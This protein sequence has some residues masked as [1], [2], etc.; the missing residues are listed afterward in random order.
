MLSAEL[1]ADVSRFL[2]R[3]AALLDAGQFDAWLELMDPEVTYVVPVR[4][5]RYGPPASEFS[6]TSFHLNETL[7]T[8]R[9]RVARLQTKYAWAED[10]PTHYRHFVSNIDV[11][12]TAEAVTEVE[13]NLLLY[14]GRGGETAGEFV[15]ARRCDV[16]RRTESGLRL[17]SRKVLADQTVWPTSALTTFL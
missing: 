16:L 8:L 6:T 15:T 11:G 3:E 9:M 17:L 7:Y 12:A 2:V 5:A 10:P 4:A 13:S 1:L 14:R